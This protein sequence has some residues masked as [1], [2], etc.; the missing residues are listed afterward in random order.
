[1]RNQSLLITAGAVLLFLLLLMPT[2]SAV[3]IV[4]NATY[5]GSVASGTDATWPA[6]R[7]GVGTTM[8]ALQNNTFSGQTDSGPLNISG[9]YNEHWRGLITWDTS[10]I[11]DNATLTSAIVSVSGNA[12]L[13]QLGPVNFAIIDANPSN[14]SAYVMGDYNRTNF[15]RMAP[16]LAFASFTNGPGTWNNLTLNPLG[17][18]NIS[19]TGLTTFMFTHSVDVDNGTFTWVNSSMSAFEIKGLVAD[20]G[21]RTPFITINYDLP[22]VVPVLT[23]AAN[24]T[25]VTAGTPT[26]VNF[27]VRNQSSGL[28]VSGATVTL[29]GVATVSGTTSAGGNVTLLV[30]ATGAGTITATAS[31]AG[32]TSN[33]T[34]VTANAAPGTL[35]PDKIG[36]YRNG[37]WYLDNIGNGTFGAGDSA[38][39]F[40]GSPGFTPIVGDWN[41]TGNSYIGLTNGQLWYL[42]WNGNG[43]FDGADKSYNFGAPG[44]MNVTG[45]WNND[46]LTD[47]GV[48]NGQQWYLDMNN[49]GTYD[50]GIDKAYNFGAPGWTPMVG[51]WN[52]TGNSYIG[53]TNGYQ[54]YL[55]WNGNGTFDSGVDKAY[56]FGAPGW[57]PMVGDWNA[58][59]KSY[60]GVTNGYQWY[61]DWNGNGTFDGGVDKAYNFGAP[62]WTPMVGDWNATGFTYIG[63]TNGQQ[64]Y[65]DWN[66]NGT[67]DGGVDKAYNFGAPGWAAVLGKWI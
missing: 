16:D 20:N 62:G 52:A 2:A 54:W 32:Y 60:I 41:A 17:L 44:W 48:T 14:R 27:M 37:T 56:N 38:F 35:V 46:G 6:M 5:D 59:G 31:M 63:V 67:F 15:T 4:V 3:Q 9:T 65:Q 50:S 19:K 21:T 23:I 57:T 39:S 24:Q 29:T 22:V 51:D 34:T 12:N 10:A 7:N 47:I 64:W 8:V 53:V 1:M 42:D 30:N 13:N 36:V 55:D 26:S 45:D 58:T 33:T 25:T 66:G 43:V 11:P 40:G 49:N 28:A 61:L 18:T